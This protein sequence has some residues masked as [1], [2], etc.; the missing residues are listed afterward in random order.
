MTKEEFYSF[1]SDS[2]LLDLM[3]RVKTSD[4][5]LDVINLTETQHSDM[6]AWCLH[7]N[8]GHA[9]GDAVV[10]DFLIA[11][12]HAGHETNKFSNK[13]FFKD[14]TPGRI[15]TSSFGGAYVTRE[16]NLSL[17][18]G[19]SNHRLDL[20]LIDPNNKLVVTIE[21]KVGA[22]LTELQLSAYYEQVNN[23]IASRPVFK[24]YSFAYV[25]VDRDLDKHSEEH[26][27]V[28]GNKWAFLD[29]RWLQASA[30]RARHQMD[31]NNQAVQ[32]LMAYCQRQTGWQ[33][34]NEQAIS[35]HAAELAA[36]YE[37]VV[38]AIAVLRKLNPTAWTPGNFEGEHGELLTFIQQNRQLCNHLVQARGIGTVLTGIRKAIPGLQAT[39]ICNGRAWLSFATDSML[40]PWNGSDGDWPLF[41]NVYREAKSSEDNSRFTVRLVWDNESF[42]DDENTVA[43]LRNHMA[44]SYTGLKKFSH[45]AVRRINVGVGLT[46][47]AAVKQAVETASHVGDLVKSAQQKG[48]FA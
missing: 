28:L 42:T 35:E 22:K 1:L 40:A 15:R 6:L 12:Y 2:H 16:F 9:Q 7:P 26:L 45:S 46:A 25:V 21:N 24:D 38:K 27:E 5:F 41:V 13:T 36:K 30:K 18:D 17:P 14:W 33:P 31:R 20:F 34:P 23:Q 39:D 8:E 29:Y 4:D 43:A 19:K 11:A 37:A 48:L 32:L 10:K 3:E 47:H 44:Q